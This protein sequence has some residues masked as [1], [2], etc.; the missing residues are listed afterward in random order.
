MQKKVSTIITG[1]QMTNL[2]RVGKC[3]EVNGMILKFNYK[4]CQIVI[5]ILDLYISTGL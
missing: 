2:V 4:I 5:I 3:I 1:L